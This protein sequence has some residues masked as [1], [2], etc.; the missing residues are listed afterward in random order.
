MDACLTAALGSAAGLA[1]FAATEGLAGVA[2]GVA[3]V[4]AGAAAGGA[5]AA[6]APA[7]PARTSLPLS[8]SL[9]LP[10]LLMLTSLVPRAPGVAA[11]GG[12]LLGMVGREPSLN[13]G[14]GFAGRLLSAG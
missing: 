1:V 5:G 11:D 2:A 4:A 6:S 14:A 7:T 8:I 12:T 3:A 13:R 9:S 10:G